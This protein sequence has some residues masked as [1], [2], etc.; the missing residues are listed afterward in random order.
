MLL[1]CQGNHRAKYVASEVMLAGLMAKALSVP[2]IGELREAVRLV[3]DERARR[4]EKECL[5]WM[6]PLAVGRL[7]SHPPP[8]GVLGASD[9]TSN[10]TWC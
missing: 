10:W 8:P 5:K 4:S 1:H 2:Q 6:L 7:A 3:E 9:L